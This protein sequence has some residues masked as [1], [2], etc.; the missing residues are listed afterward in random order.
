VV[1]VKEMKPLGTQ[2]PNDS[3]AK[4]FLGFENL[5]MCP[6]QT[7]LLEISLLNPSQIGWINSYHQ[8][9]KPPVSQQ[10]F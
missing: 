4:P 8:L 1:V 3:N 9:G 10:L 7:K 6:I 2:P 5:T